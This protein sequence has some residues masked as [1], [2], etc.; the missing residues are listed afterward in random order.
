ME[1][2]FMGIVSLYFLVRLIWFI[3]NKMDKFERDILNLKEWDWLD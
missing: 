3:V 2:V 1:T